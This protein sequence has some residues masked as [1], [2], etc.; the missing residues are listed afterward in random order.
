MRFKL[1]YVTCDLAFITRVWLVDSQN[2]FVDLLLYT[3]LSG[4][5]VINMLALTLRVTHK[6]FFERVQFAMFLQPRS[7]LWA[8][9][10]D[11]AEGLHFCPPDSLQNWTP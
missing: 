3:G 8:V 5:T 7:P 1:Y 11:P 10:L 9:P 6:I 4:T 2:N